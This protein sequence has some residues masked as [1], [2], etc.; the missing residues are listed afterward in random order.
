MEANMMREE[1][2]LNMWCKGWCCFLH[3]K[4]CGKLP[5]NFSSIYGRFEAY[6]GKRR[7][8]EMRE[9]AYEKQNMAKGWR[10]LLLLFFIFTIV[11]PDSAFALLSA[12]TLSSPSNEATGISTTPTFSWSSVSGANKYW[13]MVATN[14]SVF[15]T[16][17]NA[18]SCSSCVISVNTTSTSYT[19]TTALSAG[20]PYYWKVQGYN[21]STSPYTQGNY[22][23]VYSFTTQASLLSAPTLS[24]PSNGATGISTTPTFS[25]SSVSGANKYWLMV[26]TSSSVFPTDVNASSCSSCVISVNTT[27]TSYTPTTALSVG[28]T[29]YWKV[30]GYNTSTSPYTQGNYSSVYSFTTQA[31]L[32]SAPT[33]SSPSNGATGISTTPTFSWS[34][35]SGANKY[36]LMVATSSSVF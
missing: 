22:S 17:V 28:T 35:V 12:P 8:G 6:L 11:T 29:Y 26:A 21:T 25:W 2:I 4:K 27:S 7:D 31:S 30:Q 16:D 36:W 20:T 32:L 34:S 33:L 19:P 10:Y 13:L 9:T 15:P 3:L 23:S 1:G 14:S 24:S 18:S 5:S